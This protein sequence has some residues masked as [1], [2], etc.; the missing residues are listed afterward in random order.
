MT[1]K[2]DYGS[3]TVNSGVPL[4]MAVRSSIDWDMAKVT[5]STIATSIGKKEQKN[6]SFFRF[7]FSRLLPNLPDDL[8]P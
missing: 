2:P 3:V 6:D 4:K 8:L 7:L 1:G 5:A